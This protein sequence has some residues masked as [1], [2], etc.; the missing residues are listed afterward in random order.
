MATPA[1]PRSNTGKVKPAGPL[2]IHEG[3]PAVLKHGI[4]IKQ[5]MQRVVG[6]QSVLS[7]I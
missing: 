3:D 7:I 4:L 2:V 1:S 5:G 6:F